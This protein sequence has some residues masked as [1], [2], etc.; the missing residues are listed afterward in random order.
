MVVV[1]V[2]SRRDRHV[3]EPSIVVFVTELVDVSVAVDFDIVLCLCDVNAV[4]HVNEALTFERDTEA[5]I[6]EV[7]KQV[8]CLFVVACNGKVIHLSH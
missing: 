2:C 7:E 5:V 8:C 3:V 4:K 1:W 6:D